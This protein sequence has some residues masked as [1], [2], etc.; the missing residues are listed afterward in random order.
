MSSPETTPDGSP[1]SPLKETTGKEQEG[2]E[3][4]APAVKKPPAREPGPP[5]SH[6]LFGLGGRWKDSAGEPVVQCDESAHRISVSTLQSSWADREPSSGQAY[7]LGFGLYGRDDVAA[8]KRMTLC[9]L[10]HE[11]LHAHMRAL[12]LHHTVVRRGFTRPR[13]LPFAGSR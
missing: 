11:G 1:G 5:K 13:A 12:E 7:V 9:Q 4:S 2:G 8:Y 3:L 6:P 10:G